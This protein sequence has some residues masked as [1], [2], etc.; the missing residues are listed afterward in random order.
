M[1]F[2]EFSD[3]S[4][5]WSPCYFIWCQNDPKSYDGELH[6]S[7]WSSFNPFH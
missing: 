5:E 3:F 7:S 2:P 6:F 4:G 1:E